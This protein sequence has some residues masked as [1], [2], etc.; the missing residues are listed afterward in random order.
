MLSE[1]Q[2]RAFAKEQAKQLKKVQW[3]LLTSTH[4]FLG[5]A[6]QT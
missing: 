1:N 6:N 5:Q 2:F 3:V 4:L